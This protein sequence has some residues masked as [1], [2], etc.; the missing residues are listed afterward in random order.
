MVLTAKGFT[1]VMAQ[2]REPPAALDY[3]PTPPWAARA[4]FHHVLPVIG[5]DTI[6]SVWKS[7]CGEGHMAAVISEFARAPV[8]ASDIYA[9]GYG[10]APHDFLHD[11]PLAHPGWTT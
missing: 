5:I 1:A 3:F 2:R 10:T 6:A 7:A 9:Y 4:L 11:D 8:V